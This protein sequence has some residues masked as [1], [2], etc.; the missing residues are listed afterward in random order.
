MRKYHIQ[1]GNKF[2]RLT[3]IKLD[4]IGK[5]NRSYFLFKCECGKTKIILGSL[6][7]SGNTKSCGCLSM[8]KKKSKLLPEN[9]GVINQIILGYKR[10]AKRRGLL[11][12]LTFND[13]SVIIKKPCRYCGLIPSN[14]KITKNCNGFLY[15][16]I[17]RVDSSVGYVKVNVVSCCSQCNKSKM[18]LSKN[19][20]LSWII[21]VYKHQDAMADQ[22]GI[23]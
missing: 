15:S 20:F 5:H 17:D 2:N 13:V 21:R 14:N 18:A 8:E 4:H 6:V 3:A 12:E 16:G 11:W 23:N 10:H 1:P 7:R 22:W 19:E 9:M